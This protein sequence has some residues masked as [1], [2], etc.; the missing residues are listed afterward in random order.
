MNAI[1]PMW[2]ATND[3]WFL[4]DLKPSLQVFLKDLL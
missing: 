3:K 1:A 4:S 2:E